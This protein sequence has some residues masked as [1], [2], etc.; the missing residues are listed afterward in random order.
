MSADSG[1]KTFRDSDGLWEGHDISQVA[2]P[3]AWEADKEIV[4]EFYNHRRRQAHQVEPNAGHKALADFDVHLEV[5]IITQNLD[6]LHERAGSS[7]V[8]YL[9]G[10]LAIVRSEDDR[11]LVY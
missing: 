7:N 11:S 9:H 10:E 2:T 8:V 6:E 5:T 3:Q 4:L 1:L